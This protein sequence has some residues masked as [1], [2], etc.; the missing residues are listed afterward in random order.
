MDGRRFNAGEVAYIGK[1]GA[2]AMDRGGKNRLYFV[3]LCFWYM[4]EQVTYFVILCFRYTPLCSLQISVPKT[5]NHKTRIIFPP[6]VH[7]PLFLPSYI[8]T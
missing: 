8:L 4:Y 6:C 5:H 1:M 7:R 2:K 3:I